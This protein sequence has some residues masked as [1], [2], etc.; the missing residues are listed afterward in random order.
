MQR[1]RE[2][3]GWRVTAVGELM[4]S[5]PF[6][7]Y[8]EPDFLE[9]K[10]KLEAAD[11]GYGHLEMNFIDQDHIPCPSRGDWVGSYMN[12][13]PV[14][15]K[16]I[17]WLGV[18]IMS[19]ANNHSFD[20]GAEGL[21]ENRKHC[22]DAG[23]ASAGTGRD[24]EEAGAPAF[25]ESPMGRVALISTTSGNRNSEWANLPKG[26]IPARPGV[27]PLRVHTRFHV[28]QDIAD[29]LKKMGE[30][31]KIFATKGT[32]IEG[33]GLSHEE[34][35]VGAFM[36]NSKYSGHTYVIDDECRME[37]YNN[38]KDLER[39][40]RGVKDAR[41]VSD[42][43]MVGHHF[44]V[45][46]GPRG[47]E[48]TSFAREFAHAV[49][50]AG[51]DMY[52]GHGWH[53]TLGIEIYKGKPIIYGM[54]NIFAQS[55]FLQ[56]VP[57]DSFEVWNHDMDKLPTL[58]PQDEPLHPGLDRPSPLWWSSAVYEYEFD[59][60]RNI[61]SIKLTPVELGRDYSETEVIITRH[62]GQK[63]EGRPM[64]AH[65]EN[66]RLTLERFKELSA[67]YGTEITIEGEVAYWRA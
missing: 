14:I 42:L 60:N 63:C 8:D 28:T 38:R 25:Y 46:E 2:K 66:A 52:F 6:S 44:N 3:K 48:P 67:L 56:K 18:D 64:I 24:L 50:D 22:I 33:D 41:K 16:D 17:K 39:I 47:D 55:Q 15:A 1:N 10:K 11:V 13:D 43:V 36:E 32:Y 21:V 57:Y 49:I 59:E 61:K 23:I 53:R 7:M 30:A 45:S 62:T 35:A 26:M 34:F 4:V 40:I 9:I 31:L 58:L 27:N 51:A 5:R 20:F 29:S 12:A 37:I 19:L 54:G 65:G